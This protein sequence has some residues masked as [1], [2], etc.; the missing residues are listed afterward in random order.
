MTWLLKKMSLNHFR[1]PSNSSAKRPSI[2]PNCIKQ[3]WHGK[4]GYW[5]YALDDLWNVLEITAPTHCDTVRRVGFRKACWSGHGICVGRRIIQ[6]RP[7]ATVLAGKWSAI[8]LCTTAQWFVAV[9]GMHLRLQGV[10]Y[11]H[12][13]RI[14]HR[15][16]KLENLLLDHD[17]N[18]KITDFGF[19]NVFWLR[20]V[21]VKWWVGVPRSDG[22]DDE[23]IVWQSLL[24]RS[25]ACEITRLSR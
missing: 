22:G 9:S 20:W 25:R 13:L 8:L 1:L 6:L 14:V 4:Y 17:R 12:E 24:R 7:R 10:F 18:I 3:N 16:L 2:K 19:S 23:H 15:D 11:L 21:W 5:R